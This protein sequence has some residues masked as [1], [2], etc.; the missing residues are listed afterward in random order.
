MSAS[1]VDGQKADPNLT[2]ML[3]MVFQLITF[4]MLV[5]NLRTAAVDPTIQLPRFGSAAPATSDNTDVLVLNINAQG[6]LNVGGHPG[7]LAK[8]LEHEAQ[9]ARAKLT[10]AAAEDDLPTT[11]VLRADRATEFTQVNRVLMACQDVGF[12][13]VSLKVIDDRASA[14]TT[15][16]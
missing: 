7:D 9:A 3:D 6:G 13:N 2:P 10:N 14:P 16:R 11:V 15:T 8:L 12:R 5:L 4:F 1:A